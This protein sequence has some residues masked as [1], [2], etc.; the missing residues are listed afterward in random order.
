[1]AHA[2][3]EALEAAGYTVKYQNFPG[4]DHMSMASSRPT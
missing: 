2:W 4:T 3:L 1:M